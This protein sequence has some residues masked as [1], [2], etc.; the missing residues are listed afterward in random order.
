MCH[1]CWLHLLP[2]LPLTE[3]YACSMLHRMGLRPRK[4]GAKPCSDACALGPGMGTIVCALRPCL[5]RLGSVAKQGP[6]TALQSPWSMSTVHPKLLWKPPPT[7][8]FFHEPPG[9]RAA[10]WLRKGAGLCICPG[11]HL[12][13]GLGLISL[14]SWTL[15]LAWAS[16]PRPLNLGCSV[17][18]DSFSSPL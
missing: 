15:G 16:G 3:R 18:F 7:L 9:P 6:N 11:S 10:V 5:E 8:L 12:R 2:P 1:P 14:I 13:T 17:S 4:A